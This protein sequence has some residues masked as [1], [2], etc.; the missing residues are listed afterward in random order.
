MSLFAY[1]GKLPPSSIRDV[2]YWSRSHA[3]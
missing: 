2:H 1:D 3:L